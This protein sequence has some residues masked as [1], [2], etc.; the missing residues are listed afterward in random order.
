MIPAP[1][2]FGRLIA[3]LAPYLDQVVIIGGWAHRLYRHHPAAQIL[4][5]PP[6]MTL[7]A[8]VALDTGVL[9][10]AQDIRS[11]LLAH[12]FEEEFLG[13]TARVYAHALPADDQRAAD[14]W[15][16]V[17]DGPVQ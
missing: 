3:A 15:D 14:L 12:G 8:D 17:I 9:I 10:Q 4:E 16:T 6:L 5:Y 13:V 2:S 1:D 11:R 7:D